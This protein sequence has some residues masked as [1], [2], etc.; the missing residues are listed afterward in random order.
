MA[1]MIEFPVEKR[2]TWPMEYEHTKQQVFKNYLDEI[3]GFDGI[4]QAAMP[5]KNGRLDT[6][7][8]SK[9]VDI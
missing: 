4:V 7:W 1:T 8:V 9:Q 2:E 5:L 3:G 6:G